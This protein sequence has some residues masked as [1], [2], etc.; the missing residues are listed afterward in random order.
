MGRA[1]ADDSYL[2]LRARWDGL[3]GQSPLVRAAWLP[4]IPGL[5][6][7]ASDLVSEPACAPDLLDQLESAIFE[8]KPLP[9]SRL[10]LGQ[11]RAVARVQD[12]TDVMARKGAILIRLAR[13]EDRDI[14]EYTM[15]PGEPAQPPPPR[16]LVR[17]TAVAGLAR[18]NLWNNDEATAT[19]LRE[20][21]ARSRDAE[22]LLTARDPAS[23]ELVWHT[24]RLAGELGVGAEAGAFVDAVRTQ[25]GVFPLTSVLPGAAED[26]WIA[27]E[28]ASILLGRQ[29]GKPRTGW[30]RAPGRRSVVHRNAALEDDW[31]RGVRLGTRTSPES[32]RLRAEQAASIDHDVEDPRFARLR[33]RILRDLARWS[34]PKEAQM[35]LERRLPVLAGAGSV[36]IDSVML[37]AIELLGSLEGADEARRIE[38][39]LALERWPM[40]QTQV[41]QP[42]PSDSWT[43]VTVLEK[44]SL[45][46]EARRALL[47]RPAPLLRHA[48]GRA[49][50]EDLA[51]REP[52][53]GTVA[54]EEGLWNGSSSL[55]VERAP[56]TL[57]GALAASTSEEDRARG[58]RI[59]SRWMAMVD[60]QIAE[61]RG[62]NLW[63]YQVLI[64]R[65]HEIARFAPALGL[66]AEAKAF[67]N[68]VRVAATTAPLFGATR[69]ANGPVMMSEV[70]ELAARVLAMGSKGSEAQRE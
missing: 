9:F 25:R 57:L 33:C 52:V 38:T 62:S 69:I 45:R 10:L 18:S 34:T 1:Y 13:F 41:I 27:A 53:P 22:E 26:L 55:L 46:N 54:D 23:F 63:V 21:L 47:A 24:V 8:A 20:R 48:A 60:Q 37:C 70:A 36:R 65:I 6:P 66:A 67:V 56:D 59:L 30:S 40:A 42:P 15:A 51:E 32:E 14:A 64:D 68:R 2:Y 12:T 16:G 3:E 35:R 7:D 17:L 43:T 5:V 58:R 31:L 44:D 49:W 4:E 61:G 19:F 50:L 39:L 29:Q 11:I 28:Q